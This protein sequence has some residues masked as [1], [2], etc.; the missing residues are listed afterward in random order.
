MTNNRAS[1]ASTSGQSKLRKKER[2][3][4]VGYSACEH[5]TIEAVQQTA[6]SG[7]QVSRVL[8]HDAARTSAGQYQGY[9]EFLRTNMKSVLAFD[10]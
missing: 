8:R 4:E 3:I 1:F 9:R 2:N 7:Y 6:V 5:V 10:L